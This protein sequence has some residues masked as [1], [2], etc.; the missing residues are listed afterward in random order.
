MS[1]LSKTASAAR[2]F[3]KQFRPLFDFASLIEEAGTL[4]DTINGLKTEHSKTAVALT[5]VRD[6]LTAAQSVVTQAKQELAATKKTQEEIKI[7]TVDEQIR[8]I[9]EAKAQAKVIVTEAETSAKGV[10]S[11]SSARHL[12]FEKKASAL[13]NEIIN[14]TLT[15]DELLAEIKAM[16][17]RFA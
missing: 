9:A 5:G 1:D 16:L 7:S 3:L 13:E 12:D 17:E 2:L 6:D 10:L 15:R 11:A 8:L 14:L 4:E